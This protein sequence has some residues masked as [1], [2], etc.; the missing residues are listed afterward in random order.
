METRNLH[1]KGS[2]LLRRVTALV[3]ALC[4]CMGLVPA[5]LGAKSV[6]D[7]PA[8]LTRSANKVFVQIPASGAVI[9]TGITYGTGTQITLPAGTVCQLLTDNYYTVKDAAGVE[10]KY[11]GLYYNNMQYQV[12]CADVKVLSEAELNTYIENN[13]WKAATHSTLKQSLNLMGDVRVYA[14][15]LALTKL[16]Y[17]STVLDGDYGQKT[18]DA[19]YKFQ[20]AA[21]LSRDGDA[22]PITQAALYSM[23]LGTSSTTN[24]GGTTTGSGST[25]IVTGN[26]GTL[27]TSASVNLREKASKNSPRLDIVPINTTLTFFDTSVSGNVTW[28]KVVYNDL[29]GWIMGTYVKATSSGTGSGTGTGNTGGTVN[30]L[31]SLKTIDKVNIRKTA[32]KSSVRLGVVPKG[33]T[34]AFTDTA[35]VGG[36][37]WYKITYA[38]ETGWIMGTYT[39]L[40]AGGGGVPSGSNIV[41][42]KVTINKAGTAVRLTPGGKRSGTLLAKGSMVDMLDSPVTSGGYTWYKVKLS[43]G[44][45]GYVRGDCATASTNGTTVG[46][47]GPTTSKKFIR[48]PEDTAM[49]PA[50]GSSKDAVT[51][52]GGTVLMMAETTNTVKGGVE[53]CRLYYEG[54]MY[55]VPYARVSSGLLDD[56]ALAAHVLSLWNAPFTGRFEDNDTLIGD[57]SVYAMQVA[58]YVLGYYTGELDGSYGNASEAAVRNFQRKQKGV[59]IDGIM[60][61]QTWPLMAAK[62]KLVSNG[63][64][65]YNPGSSGGGSAVEPE[66]GTVYKVKKAKWNY[67]DNGGTLFPKFTTAQVMDVETNKVFTVYRWA[68]GNHADC[69][70]STANDTKIMCEIAGAKYQSQSPTSAQLQKIKADMKNDSANYCWPDFN[71]NMGGTDIKDKWDRR[72]AWLNVNGTVYCVSIYGYPHGWMDTDKYGNAKESSFTKKGY[73]KQNNYYGMMCIHFVGSKTHGGNAINSEH[74]AAIDKA[75]SEAKKRWGTL[76]E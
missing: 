65:T 15:Q 26:S 39:N 10:T 60:G 14:L 64:T 75:Y 58:L 76:V 63:S 69:V 46:G 7:T 51:V 17:Y 45:I 70:P 22:G 18:D 48:I 43:N 42:G 16:G 62:A 55:Y 1:H 49:T 44:L 50:I 4:L 68:G 57:V 3:L 19:V 34:L 72:A 12:R 21:G 52:P 33:I 61:P 31:G 41:T 6:G 37:T 56:A 13:I 9:F 67:D 24:P 5:A 73:E 74:Q 47:N 54:K 8:A 32:S 27:K 11:Y 38:N 59:E 53:Y 2:G 71:G 40:N 30:A 36:V 28:Y 35:T 29:T 25:G 20:R 23:V 66:F